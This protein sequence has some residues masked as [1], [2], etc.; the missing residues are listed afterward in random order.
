MPA[1][2]A[3]HAENFIADGEALYICGDRLDNARHVRPRN[4]GHGHQRPPLRRQVGISVAQVPVGGIDA[5]RVNADEHLARLQ[6]GN[7]RLFLPSSKAPSLRS[8]TG[9]QSIIII[10]IIPKG[11]SF[12]KRFAHREMISQQFDCTKPRIGGYIIR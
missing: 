5:D 4:D 9:C 2:L 12:S 10:I 11:G 8:T 6:L 3:S 7:R 1:G